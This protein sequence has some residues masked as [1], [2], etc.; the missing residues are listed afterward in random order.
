M[1]RILKSCLIV[2]DR[3][4][5]VEKRS[6][7]DLI[8]MNSSRSDTLDHF[9]IHIVPRLQRFALQIVLSEKTV[10][11]QVKEELTKIKHLE[12]NKV[13]TII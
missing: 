10:F 11:G 8:V 5:I 3:D 2:N 1:N 9:T 4:E 13:C 12:S 7:I 6:H